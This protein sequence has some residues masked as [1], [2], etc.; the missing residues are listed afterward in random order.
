MYALSTNINEACLQIDAI[1]KIRL[2][3]RPFSAKFELVMLNYKIESQ[4]VFI[5]RLNQIIFVKDQ[6]KEL[7]KPED[8]KE[9][10][11]ILTDLEPQKTHC[12]ACQKLVLKSELYQH[13]DHCTNASTCPLCL[14]AVDNLEDH[15]QDC[16]KRIYQCDGC[17]ECFNTGI[18]CKAH[19][20]TCGILKKPKTS[21]MDL[22]HVKILD[23]P[24]S[25]DH[26]GVL[27]DHKHQIT[28][29]LKSL[30]TTGL[31]F[32]LG[33]QVKMLKQ[34]NGDMVNVHFSTSATILLKS[35]NILQSVEHHINML[36]DKIDNYICNGSGW[37][38]G[39]MNHLSIM[40]TKYHPMGGSSYIE[41][42]KEIKNKKS[43]INIQNNDQKCIAW[44]ILAHKHPQPNNCHRVSHYK[45]Y[46]AELNLDG[47]SFPTPLKDIKKIE[48]QNALAIN[49]YTYDEEGFYP[50]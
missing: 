38:V 15:I 9:I 16:C 7:L 48:D 43:L 24:N 50:I 5:R 31:K 2:Q 46:L 35:T 30:M 42:P 11:L 23:L 13:L 18:K 20:S 37:I 4:P 22:F 45:P 44:C 17:N 36:V 1:C 25:K 32:Y 41:L 26:E 21:L 12:P 3:Q 39:N 6:L 10:Y 49:I 29:T 27:N 19:Q 33:A 40:S 28:Q 8:A 34:I 47:I 14:E